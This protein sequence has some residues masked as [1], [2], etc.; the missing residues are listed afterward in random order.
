M[1]IN[2]NLYKVKEDSYVS[3]LNQQEES[4]DV[5]IDSNAMNFIVDRLTDMYE[6][7]VGSIVRELLSNAIDSTRKANTNEP[8]EIHF[9]S[10]SD[11]GE[12]LYFI[13]EDKGLGMDYDT[14]KNVYTKYGN[15]TKREDLTQIGAFGLGAKVPLCYTNSF[16][17]ETV[18][19][20]VKIV[21]LVERDS[22]IK[23]KILERIETDLPNGTKIKIKVY[24][25][26]ILMFKEY[27]NM[28]KKY[29]FL[30][31]DVKFNLYV[32]GNLVDINDSLKEF[33]KNPLKLFL[34]DYD[35]E[36]ELYINKKDFANYLKETNP[37]ISKY[38]NLTH[39]YLDGFMYTT[40][41][42]VGGNVIVNLKVGMVDFI[43]SR[44]SIDKN[45][46]YYVLTDKI[47]KALEENLEDFIFEN[48]ENELED[49]ILENKH[50]KIR[51]FDN[52]ESSKYF[53]FIREKINEND[54]FEKINFLNKTELLRNKYY[55]TVSEMLYG[56]NSIDYSLKV[57]EV[58]LTRE[59]NGIFL[60]NID[61]E[62]K[63]LKKVL[64]YL[65]KSYEYKNIYF[66]EN[67]NLDSEV[68]D[69][70]SNINQNII[71]D[72]Q[73][74]N[75]PKSDFTVKKEPK[76]YKLKKVIGKTPE[77]Y[78]Y[79]PYIDYSF[80]TVYLT[81]KEIKS[82]D[83]FYV[84]SYYCIKE[85][86]LEIGSY[87]CSEDLK[88]IINLENA[89]KM[90]LLNLEEKIS[91]LAEKNNFDIEEFVFYYINRNLNLYKTSY[92]I[93]FLSS[94]P[95]PFSLEN[96]SEEK[97]N[98][99]KE[100]ISNML[101]STDRMFYIYILKFLTLKTLIIKYFLLRIIII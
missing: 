29:L 52:L 49:V 100:I 69:I 48:I 77:E 10:L 61:E 56:L 46:R 95:Y 13:V 58:Q 19:D 6:D 67:K 11:D 40:E 14:I 73:N 79:S 16:L 66:L 88:N 35:T 98:I 76:K 34:E 7:K 24:R 2:G 101:I 5:T 78:V 75:I 28:L 8:I 89:K 32:E 54:T 26:D 33:C 23:F 91:L 15:S 86:D 17:V 9:P 43:S 3:L 82:L 25:D 38:F 94:N 50:Y 45:E 60:Y 74:F 62:Y 68:I 90:K 31:K 36:V 53:S 4:I 21:G 99:F 51:N 83:S 44:E 92:Y 84:G 41:R 47:L 87:I 97:E 22:Q 71:I 18:K 1:S 93:D 20:G 80:E 72:V 64:T 27:S 70:L 30:V 85:N 59:G 37:V 42:F 55:K 65:K 12:N 96:I 39:F 57:K 63:K 81:F